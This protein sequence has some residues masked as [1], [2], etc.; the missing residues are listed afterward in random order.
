M[1]RNKTKVKIKSGG[2]A[3]GVT[4]GPTDAD[5][6]EVAG[7]LGFDF[8]I[9]DCEHDLFNEDALLHLIRAADVQGITAIVR[10]HNNPELILHALDAG[11][12]GVLAARVNTAADAQAVV[13]AGKFHPDELLPASHPSIWSTPR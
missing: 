7:L 12:Q 6:I 9:I 3:F 10:M 4:I 1:N 5:L 11:A 2:V 13:D 8:A